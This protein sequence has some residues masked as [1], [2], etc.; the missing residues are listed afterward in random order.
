MVA[1]IPF[2]TFFFSFFAYALCTFFQFVFW[3]LCHLLIFVGALRI[4][5]KFPNTVFQF[6]FLSLIVQFMFRAYLLD[7][8]APSGPFSLGGL[9]VHF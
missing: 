2:F 3:A 5:F 4:P 9:H 8:G 7:G 6:Y 1:L